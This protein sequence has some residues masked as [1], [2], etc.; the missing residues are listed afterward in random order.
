LGL[1]GGLLVVKGARLRAQVRLLT[2]QCQPYAKRRGRGATPAAVQ[3]LRPTGPTAGEG[4]DCWLRAARGRLQC[5]RG[6]RLLPHVA[7]SIPSPRAT[8]Q[9]GTP[10][11]PSWGHP[12]QQQLQARALC[13]TAEA[14]GRAEWWFALRHTDLPPPGAIQAIASLLDPPPLFSWA[15]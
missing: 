11:S 2:S 8:T 6:G 5:D 10:P 14:R 13:P 3:L 1:R 9:T 15:R 12:D 7:G 4:D